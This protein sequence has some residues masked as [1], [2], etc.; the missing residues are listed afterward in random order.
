MILLR[1]KPQA[2]NSVQDSKDAFVQD[3]GENEVELIY[4]ESRTLYSAVSPF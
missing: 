2:P 1:G 4:S 3:I